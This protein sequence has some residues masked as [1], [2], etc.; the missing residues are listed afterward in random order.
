MV[1]IEFFQN[2]EEEE[3]NDSDDDVQN[4]MLPGADVAPAFCLAFTQKGRIQFICDGRKYQVKSQS[5][6]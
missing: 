4:E 6:A 1:P 2:V 5:P 3:E